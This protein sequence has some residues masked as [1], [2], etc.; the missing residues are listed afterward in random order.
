MAQGGQDAVLEAGS[1][2]E[3]H[4]SAQALPEPFFES[5]PYRLT[6]PLLLAAGWGALI[7]FSVTFLIEDGRETGG[8][9]MADRGAR[10]P[11]AIE[12]AARPR[13]RWAASSD[14]EETA[15]ATLKT[16]SASA[17][18]LPVTGPVPAVIAAP[19]PR[20]AAPQLGYVGTWGPTAYACLGHSKRRGYLPATITE[21]GAKAGHTLCRFRNGRREGA[22]WTMAADCSERG[23]NWSAQVRLIVDGDRLTWT[24]ANG[25]SSYVRCGRRG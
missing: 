9:A 7:A 13:P 15:P 22:A 24:S 11:G 4:P 5:S 3:P 2:P 16:V 6:I 21:G 12:P 1:E 18:A 14:S 19:A 17:D 8:F 10:E 20:P 25:S 23:R